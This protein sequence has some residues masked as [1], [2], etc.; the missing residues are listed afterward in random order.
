MTLRASVWWLMATLHVWLTLCQ[1]VRCPLCA[2]VRLSLL[3]GKSS[4]RSTR[5]LCSRIVP[6][7]ALQ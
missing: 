1:A 2:A 3:W 5:F 7:T 4:G 6:Y